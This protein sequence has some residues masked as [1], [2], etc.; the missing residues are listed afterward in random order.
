MSTEADFGQWGPIV[1]APGA[2]AWWWFTWG[3][4]SNHWQRFAAAPD[5]YP[6]SVQIVEEWWEKDIS[7]TTKCLVHWR[8]NGTTPV[9]FRPK[10]IVLPNR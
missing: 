2:N 8:N 7:G 5:N 9:T 3:F 4:D 1:M 10:C 6:A